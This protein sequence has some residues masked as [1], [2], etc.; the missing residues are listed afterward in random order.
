MQMRS[1]VQEVSR[2]FPT[3]IISGRSRSKV[4]STSMMYHPIKLV[5]ELIYYSQFITEHNYKSDK[6][7]E[8]HILTDFLCPCSMKVYEFVKLKEVLYAGSHGMDIMAPP[9]QANS[10]YAGKYQTRTVDENV[11]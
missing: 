1:A 6:P 3:A 11:S 8:C 7:I 4:C 10:S 9:Q 5:S 2:H